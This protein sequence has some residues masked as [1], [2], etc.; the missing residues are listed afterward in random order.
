MVNAL[1]LRAAA[2]NT[3][4]RDESNL[5]M[6]GVHA[7]PTPTA[8]SST[9]PGTELQ[10][11][12]LKLTLMGLQDDI[13]HLSDFREAA[14]SSI[15]GVLALVS[16]DIDGL[17]ITD[18]KE[19][20]IDTLLNDRRNLSTISRS[21]FSFTNDTSSYESISEEG[22]AEEHT[23]VFNLYYDALAV[24][25]DPSK[26]YGPL[27][28]EAVQ[29]R[30]SEIIQQIQEYKPDSYYY[31]EDFDLCTTSTGVKADTDRSFDL[32]SQEHQFVSIKFGVLALPDD[33]DRDAFKNEITN[34]YQ[35]ILKNI[36]GLQ[37]TGFYENRIEA[38]GNTE[39]IFLDVKAVKRNQDM[40]LIINNKVNSQEGKMEV[41]NRI[42]S[43]TDEEGRGI[44]WCITEMGRFSAEPCASTAA[45][46]GWGI[47]VIAAT[48]VLIVLG[49]ALWV[50]VVLYQRDREEDGFKE[51]CRKW[52]ADPEDFYRSQRQLVKRRHNRMEKR[53]RMYVR[54]YRN[55][56]RD[57]DRGRRHYHGRRD[58]RHRRR[59]H[60]RPR[61]ERR[62]YYDSFDSDLHDTVETLP[63]IDNE[64]Q[65][66][67]YKDPTPP[68][69]PALQP[70]PSK[71]QL[72]QLEDQFRPVQQHQRNVQSQREIL[73]IEAQ[74]SA[75]ARQ[76]RPVEHRLSPQHREML[77][78]EALHQSRQQLMQPR[79]PQRPVPTRS[80]H[81]QSSPRQE[82]ELL[83][84]EQGPVYCDDNLVN[85]P[86]PP[87]NPCRR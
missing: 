62:H 56:R 38:V 42:Q 68:R 87:C 52:I 4:M 7:T 86:D 15:K 6:G 47:S 79:Q 27:L 48:S 75:H 23:R 77:R 21:T 31:A 51:N 65:M 46:P 18:V 69:Y 64:Y 8:M 19:R 30:Y 55:H 39:D 12:P 17:K 61:R 72:L 40:E 13:P 83:Q 29:Y 36:E 71:P 32:C 58:T 11:L 9:A 37:I 26:L 81:R 16:D 14:L 80:P 73:Q 49:L 5:F 67:L 59:R 43:Y 1:H 57:E 35:D 63:D 24:V 28:I 34:I 76:T 45:L 60:Q 2:K 25:A 20:Y 70:A 74:Y 50:I 78:I 84:I 53:H 3:T 22:R 41:L 66:V 54:P 33:V 44:Q 85:R 10:T 82:Q